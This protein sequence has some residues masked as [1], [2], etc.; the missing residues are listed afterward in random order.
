MAEMKVNELPEELKNWNGNVIDDNLLLTGLTA[1]EDEFALKYFKVEAILSILSDLEFRAVDQKIKAKYN[2]SF[3]KNNWL[4]I[5]YEDSSIKENSM[6]NDLHKAADF[7][8]LHVNQKK[9]CILVHCWQGVSRS[10]TLVIAYY[11]KYKNMSV[12]EAT[13]YVRQKRHQI[14]P[15]YSFQRELKT[16]END[17]KTSNTSSCCILL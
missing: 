6:Q 5:K 2:F 9:Q 13:K 11:V 17:P 12:V 4:H 15:N 1:S 14:S 8:N 7:I 16:F 10:S 3:K